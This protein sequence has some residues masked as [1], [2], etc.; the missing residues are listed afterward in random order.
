MRRFGEAIVNAPDYKVLI[1]PAL[2]RSTGVLDGLSG[3]GGFETAGLITAGRGGLPSALQ[4]R[5]IMPF[6]FH[7]HALAQAGLAYP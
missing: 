3:G 4:A 5:H 2:I 7:L 1:W 6:I